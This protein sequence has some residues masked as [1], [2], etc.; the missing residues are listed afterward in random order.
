MLPGPAASAAHLPA[1]PLSCAAALAVLDI[2]ERENLLTRANE[3]GSR[4][5]KRAKEWQKRWPIVGDVRGLGGMQ[6]I[7]LV[8]VLRQARTS[9]RRDQRSDAILLRARFDY[10]YGGLVF[11]M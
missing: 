9:R 6:A 5:Q 3:I 11:A 7:E 2:F 10:N 1:I 8:K 4:F